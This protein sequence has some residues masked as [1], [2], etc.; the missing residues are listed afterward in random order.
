MGRKP[1]KKTLINLIDAVDA[2]INEL[3]AHR[4]E[5][6]LKLEA[7]KKM[8]LSEPPTEVAYLKMIDEQKACAAQL[9]E[10]AIITGFGGV[11]RQWNVTW[12]T[13]MTNELAQMRRILSEF[14]TDLFMYQR[15]TKKP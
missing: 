7:L 12:Y 8:P 4:R 11:G 1:Y 9:E 3:E 15:A 10:I 14:G 2:S 6:W 5:L 13:R